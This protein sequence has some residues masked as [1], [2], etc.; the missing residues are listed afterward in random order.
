MLHHFR[1][2]LPLLNNHGDGFTALHYY[3]S[4]IQLARYSHREP[5]EEEFEYGMHVMEEIRGMYAPFK[6]YHFVP[7]TTVV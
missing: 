3:D 5:T 6:V 1:Y 4:V 7:L 2:I